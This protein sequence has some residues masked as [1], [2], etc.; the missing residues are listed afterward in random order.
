MIKLTSED[1]AP[2]RRCKVEQQARLVV[3]A[4]TTCTARA[5]GACKFGDKAH[6]SCLFGGVSPVPLTTDRCWRYA[7]LQYEAQD[8]AVHHLPWKHIH[9][10]DISFLQNPACTAVI[11]TLRSVE[12]HPTKA[13][14]HHSIFR[15]CTQRNLRFVS[16]KCARSESNRDYP[17]CLHLCGFIRRMKNHQV[18]AHKC[19]VQVSEC[20]VST[21]QQDQQAQ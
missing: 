17:M 14:V 3:Q 1:K 21:F 9:T 11:T 10:C 7:F 19:K 6:T 13:E 12:V 16:T 20:Q 18:C 8:G 4:P 15:T 2:I 5:H